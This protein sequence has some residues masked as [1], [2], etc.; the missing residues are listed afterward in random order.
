MD[1]HI[2]G[3]G[4]GTSGRG[5]FRVSLGGPSLRE[6]FCVWAQR[7]PLFSLLALLFFP[8]AA[9][10]NDLSGPA[11]LPALKGHIAIL[12]DESSALSLADIL[13]PERQAAFRPVVGDGINFGYIRH[14]AWVRLSLPAADNAQG[15]L[16]LSPNFL[17]LIDVYTAMPGMGGRAQDYTRYDAG[18][19]RTPSRNGLSNIEEAVLLE[20]A[21]GKTTMAFIRI[22][23]PTSSVH[24]NVSLNPADTY[25]Y[26]SVAKV[27]VFGVWFGAM[28]AL[29]IIQF[30]F[31]YFDRKAEYPLL[32]F[33]TLGIMLI[34]FG[35][36][37]YSHVYLFPMNGAANNIFLGF[38]AWAGLAAS[39][40]AYDR[41]L[42]LKRR[43]TWLH[44]LYLGIAIT[45]AVGVL[46][47]FL[48]QGSAFGSFG[49][50]L[51]ILVGALNMVVGLRYA[52]SEGAASRLTAAAFTAIFIGILLSMLQRF[53]VAGVPNWVHNSY[54]VAG[55]VQTMLLTGALAVRLRAAEALSR[56]MTDSLLQEAQKAE[57][58]AEGLVEE[59]TRELVAA[60]GVAEDALRA[61]QQS[62]RQQVRFMEVVSHQYRTPLA[63]IRTDI[64]SI[65]LSLAGDDAANRTRIERVRRSISWLV[66]I[67]E[68]NLERSL[69]QGASFRPQFAQVALGV[70]LLAAHQRARDLLNSP[71]IRLD[72]PL[73][74]ANMRIRADAGMLELA[75]LNL[76]ENAV[77]YT[78][79]KGGAAVTLA[80]KTSAEGGVVISVQDQGIGIPVADLPHVFDSAFRGSNTGRADGTGM[81]LPLVAK[82]AAAHGGWVD[83]DSVEDE[84]T[85]VRMALPL[86]GA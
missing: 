75:V 7:L 39:A 52:N 30:V 72:M 12:E 13:E 14:A 24:L 38:N 3:A 56:S 50:S 63:A 77:K 67:L 45:G 41:I 65:G 15:V 34:Y 31:F 28:G 37:G 68:V 78:A 57:R 81:G 36:L 2:R 19:R 83:I 86:Q 33:S 58:I 8:A 42:A 29:C 46:R 76:L 59:R 23:S 84:G 1:D 20:F 22:V 66:G 5:S 16:S 44:R 32:A 69:L 40:L 49:A 73:A 9:Q 70:V 6:A 82:I 4:I 62:Q 18:D 43:S 27:S 54:G 10:A 71:D 60:R 35:N 47:A 11:G 21:A 17:D 25:S 61:E 79:I 53:G 80:L 26:E 74:V 85:C 48:E 51:S 55:L 64:D